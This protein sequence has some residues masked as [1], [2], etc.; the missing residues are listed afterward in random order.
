[1]GDVNFV[2]GPETQ[3]DKWDFVVG[4]YSNLIS[5]KMLLILF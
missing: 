2:V 3:I 4:V 1:M 5:S